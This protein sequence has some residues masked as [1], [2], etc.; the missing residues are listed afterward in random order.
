MVWERERGTR[1]RPWVDVE[2]FK[3]EAGSSRGREKGRLLISGGW[4]RFSDWDNSCGHTTH[5]LNRKTQLVDRL[6]R[7]TWLFKCDYVPKVTYLGKI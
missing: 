7:E 2:V 6:P 1:S 5:F 3:D 4:Y